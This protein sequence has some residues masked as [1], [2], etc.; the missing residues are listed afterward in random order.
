MVPRPAVTII[1]INWNQPQHT[2]T[3]VKACAAL[4]Y[5]PLRLLV[6]D[7]GSTD[8]SVPQLRAHAPQ[9]ELITNARNLGFA[10]AANIGI[11]RALA[12]GA[13]AVFLANNDS[14]LAPTALSTLVDAATRQGAGLAAPLIFWSEPPT[15]IWSAGGWRGGL[16]MDLA[17]RPTPRGDGKP[18]RVDFVTACG[19]LISRACVEQVGLF[20]E[21]FFMYYEDMDYC[22]RAQALGQ[23]ILLVPRAHMWHHGAASS[24]GA[25]SPNERYQMARSSVYYF[26]KHVR[27]WRWLVV[28][29]FRLGS[30]LK[31]SYRLGRTGRWAALRAYWRGLG[32]G[33]RA[34]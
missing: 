24:G 4:D 21:R 34:P 30:A 7:N 2:I 9:V 29:P 27:G 33:L 26:R 6:V 32:A 28:L 3:F 13:A 17:Q 12:Q 11:R 25:D 1:T 15:A 14:I 23:R 5:A 20:D 10:A 18:L 22:L 8:D 16:T 19:M 31:S